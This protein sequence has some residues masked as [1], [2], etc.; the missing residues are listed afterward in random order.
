LEEKRTSS[1]RG[2]H[3]NTTKPNNTTRNGFVILMTNFTF[4]AFIFFAGDK[5]KIILH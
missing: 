4:I 1:E 2:G 5:S 3:E